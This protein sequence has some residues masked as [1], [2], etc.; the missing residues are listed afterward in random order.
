MREALDFAIR[1]FI[2]H[3]VWIAGASW[4][5]AVGS[6]AIFARADG[7]EKSSEDASEA[8]KRRI[9]LGVIVLIIGIVMA[10]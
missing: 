1:V 4:L 7:V 9:I 3:G 10:L 5:L 2:K 8:V 6:R